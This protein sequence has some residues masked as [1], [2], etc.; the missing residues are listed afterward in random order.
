MNR[1]SET[2][3]ADHDEPGHEGGPTSRTNLNLAHAACNRFKRNAPSVDVRPFLR[4]RTH[5]GHRGGLVQYGDCIPHFGI[6]P[7]PSV[8]SVAGD[9]ASLEFPDGSKGT[10]RIFNEVNSSGDFK[11]VFVE[12]PRSA[13]FNDEDCQ[14]RTVKLDQLWK[15]FTDLH[16]NPLH[17]PP[18]CRW[19]DGPKGTGSLWMFDG[20]HKTLATWLLGR[21]R[22]VVKVYLNLT[23][24]ATI[25]LVNSIQA[26]IPKLPLSTFELASKMD[27]EIRG[28]FEAYHAEKESGATESGFID[29]LPQPERDRGRQ[30]LRLALTNGVVD[31]EELTFLRHVQRAGA[32]K[33]TGVMTENVFKTKLLDPLL[34]RAPLVEPLDVAELLRTRERN[35]VVRVLNTLDEL[36]FTEAD[37]DTESSRE[38]RKRMAY[39]SALA[40]TSTLVRRT[41]AFVLATD[42]GRELLDKEPEEQDWGRIADAI[43]RISEHPIWTADPD[44]SVK[45]RAVLDALAKNQEAAERFRAVGLTAGYAVGVDKL[46]NDWFK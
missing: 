39:Q 32:A 22:V 5:I 44:L 35:N 27:Q 33:N 8:L 45:V 19:I 42:E 21:D 4:L 34:H 41:F 36:V 15:I 20:Q 11:Y 38:R 17:E 1:A 23:K 28:K 12:A 30:G 16:S 37:A 29:W 46:P 3:E 26:K 14:P 24:Q 6:A 10:S 18:S 43:R 9:V 7:E 31:S 40:Y 13:I 2:L 25:E